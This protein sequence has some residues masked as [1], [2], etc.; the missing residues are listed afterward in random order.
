V[1]TVDEEEEENTVG[2][3]AKGSKVDCRPSKEEVEE[4]LRSGHVPYR[5][6]CKHCIYG[7]GEDKAHY[8]GTG[9]EGGI[10][11]ISMDYCSLYEN[12]AER[13]ERKKEESEAKFRGIMEM[14]IV[15]IKD[16]KSKQVMAELVPRKGVEKFAITCLLF[17]SLITTMG[18]SI[19]P[20][21]FASDSSF[22]LS[23]LSA[24]FSY[25]E[26]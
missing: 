18:I 4:H 6:W 23:L 3:K 12:M 11:V 14:P 21:N 20:L 1:W 19:I 24:I 7:R 5:S 25:R 16:R 9:E 22:F 8:R 13:R 2:T 26:Q 17:L 15:V 10:P